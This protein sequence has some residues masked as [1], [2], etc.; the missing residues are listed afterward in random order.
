MTSD[1]RPSALTDR[2][3]RPATAADAAGIAAVHVRTWQAAYRGLL[4]QPFLDGLDV[5]E[6]RQSWLRRLSEPDDTVLAILVAQDAS[7]VLGFASLTACL[8][9][10]RDDDGAGTGELTAIYVLPRV[11]G[12]GV[13]RALLDAA[14]RALAATGISEVTLWV[15]DGNDRARRFYEAAGWTTDGTTK[16]EMIGQTPVRV[17]RYRHHLE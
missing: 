8:T 13:G 1:P 2:L 7:G 4:P 10:S 14:L 5:E 6:R 9:A 3:I 16:T 11:W 17:I 12:T 15:L